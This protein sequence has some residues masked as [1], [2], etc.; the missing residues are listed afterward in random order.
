MSNAISSHG[1]LIKRAGTT[2]GELGD[3]TPP[4]LMRNTFDTTVH[5]DNDDSYVVGIRRKG[6]VQFNINF[7]P[8]GEATHG[9]TSGL[10]KAWVD[11]SK[12]LW[13]IDFP[14][15]TKW[16]FSGFVTNISPAA[17]VDGAQTASVT[18]RPT[19]G[20]IFA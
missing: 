10:M 18:V 8:S 12:D 20:T 17:P 15:G 19:G 16:Y 1:T 6:E 4:P 3:I 5:T 13:E 7:L 9:T 2:V 14:D 11:G